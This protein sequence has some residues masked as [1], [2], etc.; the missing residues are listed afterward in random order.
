MRLDPPLPPPSDGEIALRPFED[1][2]A[3]RFATLNRDPAIER[4]TRMSVPRDPRDAAEWIDRARRGWEGE[5]PWRFAVADA[6]SNELLGYIGIRLV[7]GN[8]QIGY[9]VRR[10]ARGRGVATRALRLLA[11]WALDSAGFARI[12]LLVEPRN[13]PSRRV[14]EKAGFRA[15]GVLRRYVDLGDRRVD[16]IMFGLLPEDLA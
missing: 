15:E 8:G 7:D 16:G 10:E 11:R 3:A 4:Y 12:Q 6:R 1:D 2:D 9:W 14:A 5:G 13:E